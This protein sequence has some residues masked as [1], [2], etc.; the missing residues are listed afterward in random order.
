LNKVEK[1]LF[2]ALLLFLDD[3]YEKCWLPTIESE[4]AVFIPKEDPRDQQLQRVQFPIALES[5][6]W[7]QRNNKRAEK[8]SFSTL[9]KVQF[10]DNEEGLPGR[11]LTRELLVYL[12]TEKDGDY[13]EIDVDHLN[14]LVPDKGM[15]VSIQVLGYA[16]KQGKLLPNKKYKEIKGRNGMIKIP[17]NF[18]P[19][20]PFTDQM[21]DY[22]TF[23]RRAFINGNNWKAFI[24][25]YGIESKLLDQGFAN[26]GI[27]VV[28][29]AFKD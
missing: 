11:H 15:F 7:N 8:R 2:S 28:V 12:V 9:F 24:P 4:I 22:R 23:T 25:N 18:R 27:G 3:D 16:D 29:K 13:F 21:E 5:I 1:L 10:Y 17:T 6:N 19:L 26:Y 14:L 20:L